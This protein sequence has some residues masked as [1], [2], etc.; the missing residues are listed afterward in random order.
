MNDW[1]HTE[2][3]DQPSPADIE[4]WEDHVQTMIDAV[5]EGE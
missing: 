1:P 5:E 4:D 3:P 2:V